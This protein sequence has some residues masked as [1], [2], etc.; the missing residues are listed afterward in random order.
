VT[1]FTDQFS[2]LIVGWAL[3]LRPTQAEG[4]RRAADGLR[5][6]LEPP[7]AAAAA[8]AALTGHD[9]AL[10]AGGQLHDVQCDGA[11]L[12][13]GHV[14]APRLQTLI[15]AQ[16]LARHAA[17]AIPDAPL[18]LTATAIHPGRGQS[19][20]GWTKS[21]ANWASTSSSA[22]AST[23]ALTARAWRR[24]SASAT[25]LPP[26][27]NCDALHADR[28]DAAPR[29]DRAVPAGDDRALEALLADHRDPCTLQQPAAAL[30]WTLDRVL[31]A[32]GQL[33]SRLGN[34]GQ[35]L[36]R[37]GHHTLALRARKQLIPAGGS[38]DAAGRPQDR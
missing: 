36:E 15:R 23:R 26:T 34:T 3:S 32:A 38:A 27:T 16:E 11:E 20:D 19:A 37:H 14:I 29:P 1:V 35:T 4:A 12:A 21:A 24:S 7:L 8:I 17:G 22:T 18:F 28:L 13:G 5:A 10:I 6:L 25:A 31:A 33:E 2:R 30:E 9:A